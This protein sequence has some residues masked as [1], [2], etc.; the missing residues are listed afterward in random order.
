[1]KSIKTMLH[2]ICC[3][4]FKENR[5][6]FCRAVALEKIRRIFGIGKNGG[7]TTTPPIGAECQIEKKTAFNAFIY[8]I[9]AGSKKTN[10]KPTK[11]QRNG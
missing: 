10:K 7:A 8:W 6:R 9:Y 5:L 3:S 1:M 11:N 2:R 4:K